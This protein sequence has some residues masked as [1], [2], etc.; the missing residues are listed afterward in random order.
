[1]KEILQK[2]WKDSSLGFFV[3]YKEQRRKSSCITRFLKT[4]ARPVKIRIYLSFLFCFAAIWILQSR[5]TYMYMY[6]YDTCTYHTYDAPY[7]HT[8]MYCTYICMLCM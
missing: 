6:M 5:S 7:I 1:M 2:P 3:K 8:H 4:K